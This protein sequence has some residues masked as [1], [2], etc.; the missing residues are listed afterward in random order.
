MGDVG[1]AAR[2][3]ATSRHH[4]HGTKLAEV[5][6]ERKR[7]PN[8]QPL[9]HHTACAVRE[10][11]TFVVVLLKQLPRRGKILLFNRDDLGEGA[12]DHFGSK[13]DAVSIFT[14]RTE[15]SQRFINHV[16]ACD[17]PFLYGRQKMSGRLVVGIAYRR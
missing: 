6:V 7:A 1:L 13:R 15:Q 9:H 10:A 17:K 11:P 14:S 8:A 3:G 12:I 2:A 16:V 4:E 5:V